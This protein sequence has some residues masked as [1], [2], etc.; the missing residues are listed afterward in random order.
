MTVARTVKLKHAIPVLIFGSFLLHLSCDEVDPLPPPVTQSSESLTQA[1][2][3]TIIAHGVEESKRLAQHVVVAVS[4]REGNVLGVFRMAGARMDSTQVVVA[5]TS[6]TITNVDIAIRKARTAAFLSS[7]QHAFSTLTACFITRPHFPPGVANTAG[8]PLFGVGLSSLPGGDIMPNGSALNDRPGGLPVFK[9]GGLVGGIGIAGGTTSFDSS[10]CNGQSF[11]EI[12]AFG[13]ASNFPVPLG[14]RGDN[15]F[16]DGIRFLYANGFAPPSGYT[17]TFDSVNVPTIGAIVPGYPPLAAPTRRFPFSGEVNLDP[18][19][20]FRIRGG[21]VLT[22]NEVR[23][24][25]DQAA[26]QAARTRAAIR[27]PLGVAAQVFIAVVDTNGAVLGIWRTP[28]ATVF[29]FDV[30]A[31]KAR[32]ALAFSSPNVPDFGRRLRT[33]LGLSLMQQLAMTTRAIGY[34]AQDYFP[35]G[36]GGEHGPLFEG[37]DFAYQRRLL[38]LP[39]L[40]PYNNGITIF[41]GGIPLYKNGQ[42]VGAIGIS[43]DGVDQDDL[44]AF[45]GS[46]GFE[47]PP[48]I[49]SDR[50][51]YHNVRLPYIKVPRQPEL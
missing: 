4:D 35:P 18:V 48:E 37:T 2:V 24:I 11:D 12:I 39:G 50:F 15:I 44:I 26:A 33:I 36:I 7:D 3:H 34:L 32:T 5:G 25:I 40:P 1:D 30:A 45:A 10:L 46:Q 28:D 23:Q 22:E 49:R 17:L 8:G 16:I 20:D 41:P 42:L 27:R 19:H 38:S 47:P 31:Q 51:F 14:K 43:G 9:N 21:S 6:V 29:S 13:A